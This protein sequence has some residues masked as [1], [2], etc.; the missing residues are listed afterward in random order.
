MPDARR[1]NG[2]AEIERR[3]DRHEAF[4]RRGPPHQGVGPFP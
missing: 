4:S 1:S 2:A 3:D